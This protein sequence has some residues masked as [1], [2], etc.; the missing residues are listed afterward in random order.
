MLQSRQRAPLLAAFCAAAFA[1]SVHA[2]V[3]WSD[4]GATLV[5]ESGAGTDILG[6]A[7]TRDNSSSNTLYF[8]FHVDPLSD[9]STEEY[10]AGFQLYDGDA[11]RLGIGNSQKAWAYSVFNAA[12]TGEFNKV[13][14]DVDLRSSRPESSSPGVFLPYE[15][16]RRGIEN[17]IV[18]KVQYVPGGDDRVTVWLNPDLGPGAAEETQ[19]EGL[20]T[21]FT[22]NA[23][24]NQI[25][26]RHGGGGGGWT[27][28]D[29]AIATSFND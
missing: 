25:R 28:G 17:T 14:G 9:V 23:S 27:F 13:F 15:L 18:F 16:P 10:F 20:T 22:A 2:V 19:P 21:K 5:H 6:N 29:M 11:E 7:L 8:K 4:L 12:E 3:L 24:F 26:L 1:S